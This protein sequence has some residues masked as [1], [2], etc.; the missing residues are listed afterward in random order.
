MPTEVTVLGSYATAIVVDT[1]LIPV[2]G[3]TVIGRNYRETFGGKARTSP[4][5]RP[6]SVPRSPSSE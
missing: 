5:R 1:D 6:G 2:T 4:S 3:Q